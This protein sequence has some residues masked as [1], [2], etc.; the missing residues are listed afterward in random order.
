MN[1]VFNELAL[2]RGVISNAI[3]GAAG[4]K[5]QQLVTNQKTSGTPG[6]II[7]TDGC[8]LKCKQVFH[9]VAPSWDNGQGTAEQVS[10][11]SCIY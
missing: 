1:T 10:L 9:V 8:K 7:V 11:A 6:E 5:L 4:P 3:L 2:N